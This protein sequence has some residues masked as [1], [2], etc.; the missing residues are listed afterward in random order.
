MWCELLYNTHASSDLDPVE[1][2]SWTVISAGSQI[3]VV[4][5]ISNIP[6]T[7]NAACEGN[8]ALDVIRLNFISAADHPGTAYIMQPNKFARVDESGTVFRVRVA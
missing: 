3:V 4:T 8:V 5:I 1:A 6:P 2:W 7:L